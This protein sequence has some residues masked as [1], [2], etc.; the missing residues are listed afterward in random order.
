VAAGLTI[1]TRIKGEKVMG[2]IKVKLGP[3]AIGERAQGIILAR[4]M[5]Y[6]FTVL[7]PFDDSARYDL[8]IEKDGIFH[9]VQCKM[10]R[11]RSRNQGAIEFNAC[12]DNGHG[13]GRR[14]YIGQA[15]YFAV[16]CPENGKIYL[17]PVAEI[18]KTQGA[19]RL[20]PPHNNQMK[21]IRWAAQYEV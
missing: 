17:V 8:V 19:L 4:F 12:S 15:D 21:G 6:G 11:I 18:G 13:G 10:G 7:I 16:Y 2:E 9:S 3:K 14:H 20:D 1:K 5:E